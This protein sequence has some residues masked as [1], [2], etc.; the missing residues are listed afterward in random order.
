VDRQV[1]STSGLLADALGPFG[2]GLLL[3]TVYCFALLFTITKDIGSEIEKI[4]ANFSEW[5]AER[6]KRKAASPEREDAREGGAPSSG[7]IRVGPRPRCRARRPG[8]R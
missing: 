3:G 8:G 1:R 7:R 6:A 4:L 2:S 5:K